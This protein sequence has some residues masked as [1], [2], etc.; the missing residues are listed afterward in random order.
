[1]SA[2]NSQLRKAYQQLCS[3]QFWLVHMHG[4]VI[5]VCVF[6]VVMSVVIVTL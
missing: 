1:M 5:S 4:I 3:E 6:A 2:V